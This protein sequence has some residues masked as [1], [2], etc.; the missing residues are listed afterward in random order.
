M[1]RDEF[2]S[3]INNASNEELKLAYDI[4]G[5]KNKTIK[6]KGDAKYSAF[7]ILFQGMFIEQY[8]QAHQIQYP[9]Y[10]SD[11]ASQKAFVLREKYFPN[12][13]NL[14]KDVNFIYDEIML[15]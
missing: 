15:I 14:I 13:A 4:L 12:L 2:T 8:I 10:G 11:D 9:D 5:P 6:I 7:G 1:I 3:F